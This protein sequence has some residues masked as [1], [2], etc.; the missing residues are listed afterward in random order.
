[1]A[2]L[3]IS[4]SLV[5][6]IWEMG[7]LRTVGY[8][9][10]P[11]AILVP[12]L[13]LAVSV[14]HGVQYVNSWVDEVHAG[15]SSHDASLETFRRLAI[16][17]TIALATDVAGFATIY[18]IEIQIIREM[19]INAVLGG[20]AIIVANKMFV[21]IW[22]TMVK[23]K[24]VNA[25]IAR[26]SWQ[27]DGSLVCG[28]VPVTVD[29]PGRPRLADAADRLMNPEQS[30]E[31]AARKLAKLE[32][33]WRILQVELTA[34][35]DLMAAS[36]FEGKEIPDG[37]LTALLSAHQSIGLP[38]PRFV[39]LARRFDR[40]FDRAQLCIVKTSGVDSDGMNLVTLF[41]AEIFYAIGSIK[42]S[43]EC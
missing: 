15:R 35:R 5:A 40:S 20:L 6:C 32:E 16:A 10:D 1:M 2:L 42:T 8:G 26:V 34:L 11:F 43:A 30:A 22:L 33:E 39:V 38:Q 19:S 23:L 25:F 12:F 7:L 13:I 14:S 4:T 28:I 21:P 27:G 31:E 41:L 9:L 24:D 3:V 36:Y 37:S 18:L 29:P 17:G